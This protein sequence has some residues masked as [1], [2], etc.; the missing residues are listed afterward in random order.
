MSVKPF[1]AARVGT[2]F[3]P[4]SPTSGL[5]EAESVGDPVYS[6][7]LSLHIPAF[8]RQIM[9][10]TIQKHMGSQLSPLLA[11]DRQGVAYSF[12]V[13]NSFA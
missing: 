1:S 8:L 9:V 10:G 13:L 11:L 3:H 7:P 12:P 4:V 2:M 5:W 6:F